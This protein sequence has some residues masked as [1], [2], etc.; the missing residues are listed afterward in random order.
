MQRKK[1]NFHTYKNFQSQPSDRARLMATADLSLAQKHNSLE[2]LSTR[3]HKHY[4]INC[5]KPSRISNQ[6]IFGSCRQV[7]YLGKLETV[8]IT[9]L[10]EFKNF[11]FMNPTVLC[12][13]EKKNI[14]IISNSGSGMLEF[15]Q[16]IM[17]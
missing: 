17:Q 15:C 1:D 9:K 4:D 6:Q 10:V 14:Q 16:A 13:I 8:S 11:A 12:K 3:I 5:R 7:L 2:A